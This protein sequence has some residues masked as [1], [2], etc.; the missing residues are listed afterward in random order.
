MTLTSVS[1][2]AADRPSLKGANVASS[3]AINSIIELLSEYD[4]DTF[5]YSRACSAQ[6]V[7]GA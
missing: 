7:R 1:K 2:H 6:R 4:D 5:S 3:A